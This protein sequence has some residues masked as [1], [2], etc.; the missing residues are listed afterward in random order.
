MESLKELREGVTT[1]T[2]AAAA[3]AAAALVLTRGEVPPVVTVDTPSGPRSLEVSW[4]RLEE[5]GA[6]ASVIKDAGDDP[7]VTH[8]MAVQSFVRRR[9]G[10]FYL[11]GGEGVGTVTKPGLKV[12]VGEKAIN[13]VPRAQILAELRRYLPQ[14]GE[15]VISI[16]GGEE[17]A[18]KTYNPRLGIVGGLSIL[19]TKGVVRPMSEEALRATF[20]A[21]LDV[22]VAA[23]NLDLVYTFGNMGEEMALR[24]LGI[25]AERI[26]QVGNEI[27]YMLKE[28]HRAGVKHLTIAGHSGKLVKVAAGVFQTHSA[29]ADARREVMMALAA[30][31]GAPYEVLAGLDGCTTTE[32]MG[33]L[34]KAWDE[35]KAHHL[36]QVAARRAAERACSYLWGDIPCD[37]VIFDNEGC[38]LGTTLTRS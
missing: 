35:E 38:V 10:D 32:S 34:L 13:P 11:D 33:A 17:V 9:Q 8:G 25:G 37:A 5:D 30:L 1:G 12:A 29:V 7:D 36:W 18:H 22:K 26:V 20:K 19:G 2:C 24:A 21:D 14:G 3:T 27:G 6:R 23:G 31:E 28:A 15:A 4:A 16:P